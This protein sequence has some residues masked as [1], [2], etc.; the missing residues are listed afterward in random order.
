MV[1]GGF[2]KML[3]NGLTADIELISSRKNNLCSKRV[4]PLPGKYY[5]F[6][7]HIEKDSRLFS[8][9]KSIYRV[10]SSMKLFT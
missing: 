3:S 7:T 1:A 5:D 9:P 8:I 6:I 4:H 10:T 2:N